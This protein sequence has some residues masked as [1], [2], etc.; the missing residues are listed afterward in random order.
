LGAGGGHWRIWLLYSVVANTVKSF[1]D[2]PIYQECVMPVDILLL[3]SEH[4][5]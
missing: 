5:K 2:L 1:R 3:P 4:Q